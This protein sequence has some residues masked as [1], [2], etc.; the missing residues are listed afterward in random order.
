MVG[1]R[2]K[3]INKLNINLNLFINTLNT[4]ST[5]NNISLQRKTQ[6]YLSQKTKIKLDLPPLPAHYCWYI[7]LDKWL[8]DISHINTCLTIQVHRIASR[9]VLDLEKNAQSLV[10]R[11]L[12]V[13]VTGGKL[14]I[15][16]VT[17][18]PW[19]RIIRTVLKLT[20]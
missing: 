13:T 3:L 18:I 6:Q 14:V 1:S 7:T 15:S 10:G 19:Y 17:G 9:L 4:A 16:I 11:S 5:T 8:A 12:C 20:V 2:R